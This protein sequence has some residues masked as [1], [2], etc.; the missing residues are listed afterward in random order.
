MSEKDAVFLEDFFGIDKEEFEIISDENQDLVFDKV[1]LPLKIKDENQIN[2]ELS[3]TSAEN[4]IR[5]AVN[6]IENETSFNEVT[7]FS[8]SNI[9]EKNFW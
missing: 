7:N 9:A 2:T 5:N 8:L 1:N 4:L 3:K 6:L